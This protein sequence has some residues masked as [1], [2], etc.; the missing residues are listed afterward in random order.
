[1]SDGYKTQSPDTERAT[2]EYVLQ[3]YR[4]MTPA[5]KIAIVDRLRR[6]VLMLARAGIRDQYP[7]LSPEETE[8]KLAERVFGTDHVVVRIEE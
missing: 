6:M 1:M 4:C 5:E 8:S 7:G 2:E 3:R